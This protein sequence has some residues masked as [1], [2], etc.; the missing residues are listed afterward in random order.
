MSDLTILCI[1]QHEPHAKPFLN[2]CASVAAVL[3]MRFA[4]ADGRGVG[5]IENVLDEVIDGCP[6][7]Y[8]LRID[9]DEWISDEMIEWLATRAYREHDHWAFPRMNL[10]PNADHFITSHS[11]WPDYQTRLS[12]KAKSG[13]RTGV[14]DGSPFG[15]GELALCAIEHHKFLVRSEA[16]RREILARYEALGADRGHA[17]FS[18]PEDLGEVA[19]L[20]R[21]RVMA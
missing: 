10:W 11:L 9:D 17:Q 2:H 13:G 16:E 4:I 19:L 1:T 18:V 6:D 15:T 20:E 14:H 8:I 21:S 7:G 5:V 12:V 3:G